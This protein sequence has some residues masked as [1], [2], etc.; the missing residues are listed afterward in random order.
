TLGMSSGFRFFFLFFPIVAQVLSHRSQFVADVTEQFHD[1]EDFLS[2]DQRGLLVFH[3]ASMVA[4]LR[5][6][7]VAGPDVMRPALSHPTKPR[8]R[9][10]GERALTEWPFPTGWEEWR[11]DPRWKLPQL[12]AGWDVV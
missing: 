6:R 9:A 2:V 10:E 8:P 7:K 4:H 5:D 1:S 12:P 11:P 3:A